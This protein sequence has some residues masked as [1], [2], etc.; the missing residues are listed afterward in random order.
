MQQ[1][2]DPNSATWA[3][4]L[5]VLILTTPG[6]VS[7]ASVERAWRELRPEYDGRVHVEVV[8]MLEHPELAVRYG[9]LQSPAVV[10]GGRLR[11][12]GALGATR[13]ARLL[14]DVLRERLI[15]NG[16]TTRA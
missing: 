9:V 15:R 3:S 7:C 6:C 1:D 12:Q 14:D 4:P 11:A 13:L 8:A 16:E 5:R 2:R 10:I